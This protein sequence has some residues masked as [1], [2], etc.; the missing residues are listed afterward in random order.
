MKENHSPVKS[1]DIYKDDLVSIRVLIQGRVKTI[2]YRM[3]IKQ[4]ATKVGIDGWVTLR[5][6]DAV[7][8][9][10]IGKEKHVQ[11]LIRKCY[12]GN[13]YAVV[14]RIRQFP[15]ADVKGLGGGFFLLP[16]IG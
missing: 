1:N 12:C 2:G 16:T 8:A 7:E 15:Q 11:E 13:P 6:N 14:K 5:F 4:Q 3:W 10:F 9:L